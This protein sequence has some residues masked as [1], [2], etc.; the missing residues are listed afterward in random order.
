MNSLIVKCVFSSDIESEGRGGDLQPG[1][2][3]PHCAFINVHKSQVSGNVFLLPVPDKHVS[4]QCLCGTL[5][6]RCT[7]HYKVLELLLSILFTFT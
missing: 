7:L 6:R 2:C 3:E 5:L 4:G 1:K